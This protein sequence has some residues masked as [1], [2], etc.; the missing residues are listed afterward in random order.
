MAAEGAR[1]S[2]DAVLG[3]Q[4]VLR[5]PRKGHR[6]GHDAILLAA[7]CSATPRDHL[8]DLLSLIHI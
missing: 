6:V 8:V 1:I 5:Q 2:E 4:L 3:G 7:A